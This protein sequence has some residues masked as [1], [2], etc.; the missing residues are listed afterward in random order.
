MESALLIVIEDVASSHW[1][2]SEGGTRE[3]HKGLEGEREMQETLSLR[4]T[5]TLRSRGETLV[6]V[7][8][9]KWEFAVSG[10]RVNQVL[11]SLE[12]SNAGVSQR[13][14]TLKT[15]S[16]LKMKDNI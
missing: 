2:W 1:F 12:E 4:S 5:V 8:G 16:K 13:I 14:W 7:K 6:D 10:T 3:L 11:R 15:R 9:G